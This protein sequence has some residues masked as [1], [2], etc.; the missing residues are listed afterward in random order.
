MYSLYAAC[1]RRPRIGEY[2]S[3]PFG[4]DECLTIQQALRLCTVN[5]AYCMF[6]EDQ[7][8]SLEPGKHADLVVWSGDLCDL[9]SEE[10]LNQKA[11]MTMV[12]G[13]IVYSTD[14]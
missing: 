8:G 14:N 12:N 4:E 6:W 2:G 3:Q 11:E 7:I 1:T 13:E 10:L 5:S 9:P